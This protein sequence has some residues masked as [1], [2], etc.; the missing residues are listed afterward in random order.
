MIDTPR[1]PESTERIPLCRAPKWGL[2][3]VLTLAGFLAGGC[4]TVNRVINLP[5]RAID[6]SVRGVDKVLR[7]PGQVI[8]KAL[9]TANAAGTSRP[10]A[11]SREI[12]WENGSLPSGEVTERDAFSRA[13]AFDCQRICYLE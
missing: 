9:D 3:I 8:D 13:A 1:P 12:M 10:L 6:S 7:N 11:Y 5:L 4:G 2:A